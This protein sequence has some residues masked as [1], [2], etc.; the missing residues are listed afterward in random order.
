M[1]I[2]L[3]AGSE[4]DI[5]N[6]LLKSVK[7]AS[8]SA[9]RK[10]KVRFEYE[11]AVATENTEFSDEEFFDKLCNKLDVSELMN[12]MEALDNKYREVLYYRFV[13]GLSTTETAKLLDREP[14]TIRKQISRGK[15]ILIGSLSEKEEE[16]C[17]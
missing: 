17:L 5:R 8:I 4:A 1:E 7:N 3:N 16:K 14:S 11:E 10:R 9:I 6:Y 13:I 12:A 2:I 15:S